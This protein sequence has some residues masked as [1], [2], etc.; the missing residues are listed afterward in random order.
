MAL[1]ELKHHCNKCGKPFFDIPFFYTTDI[2][3]CGECGLKE[4]E[5]EALE[6]AKEINNKGKN[7]NLL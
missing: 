7:A 5:Q 6:L 2:F 3:V 4:L 1:T